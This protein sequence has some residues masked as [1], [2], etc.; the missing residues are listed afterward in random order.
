MGWGGV[1]WGPVGIGYVRPD[2]F[3]DHLTVIKIKTLLTFQRVPTYRVWEPVDLD[4]SAK[5][6]EGNRVALVKD[7]NIENDLTMSRQ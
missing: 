3:L 4:S 1:Q 6:A 7:G 5:S 2:Q